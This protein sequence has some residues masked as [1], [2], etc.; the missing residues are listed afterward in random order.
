MHHDHQPMSGF[1]VKKTKAFG[2]ASC[3]HM[4]GQGS[5]LRSQ[6]CPLKGP[7]AKAVVCGVQAVTGATQHAHRPMNRFE[8]K[9]CRRN[10]PRP[11]SHEPI[12]DED[13]QAQCTTTIIPCTDFGLRKSLTEVVGSINGKRKRERLYKKEGIAVRPFIFCEP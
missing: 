13:L 9:I 12:R 8:M 1:R 5:S 2:L 6:P 10:A 7:T 11:S 3:Y 4:S